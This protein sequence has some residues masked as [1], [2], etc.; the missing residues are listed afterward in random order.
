ME[1]TRE[2]GQERESGGGKLSVGV[3]RGK[4]KVEGKGVLIRSALGQ[5]VDLCAAHPPSDLCSCFCLRLG[6]GSPGGHYKEV[7]VFSYWTDLPESSTEGHDSWTHSHRDLS[8]Q[9]SAL[10]GPGM[11]LSLTQASRQ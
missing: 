2:S 7:R 5:E 8:S 11:A 1:L 10:L 6:H 4:E 9:I 3:L